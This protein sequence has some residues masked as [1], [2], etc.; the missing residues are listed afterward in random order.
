A[1][2]LLRRAELS[3]INSCVI[4]GG[5]N[6]MRYSSS[7][8]AL[9]LGLGI[10]GVGPIISKFDMLGATPALA[11]GFGGHGHGHGG[12]PAAGSSG[13]GGDDDQGDDGDGGDDDQ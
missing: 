6:Q 13:D 4:D 1:H 10:Y 3:G 2:G 5:E 7:V 8:L 11:K 9:L 12:S